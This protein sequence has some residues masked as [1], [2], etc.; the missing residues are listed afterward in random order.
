MTAQHGNL[1]AGTRIPHAGHVILITQSD[2]VA[3]VTE[4]CR[5][6]GR[7]VW[8]YERDNVAVARI[9]DSGRA[10]AASRQR[11]RAV[12]SER[13]GI[14]EAG[15]TAERRE[16]AGLPVPER[17]GAAAAAD[18]DGFAV[19]AEYRLF[20][21]VALAGTPVDGRQV[22]GI[23]PAPDPG[24]AI[25]A[26]GDH[27]PSVTAELDG[28]HLVVGALSEEVDEIASTA[29]VLRPDTVQGSG[30]EPSS[31]VAKRHLV[32]LVDGVRLVG[33]PLLAGAGVKDLQQT[34]KLTFLE[35]M[36]QVSADGDQSP[37]RTEGRRELI[38]VASV[39]ANGLP[40]AP[41]PE[42]C[43][44]VVSGGGNERALGIHGGAPQSALV[45]PQD[46]TDM[47]PGQDLP[48]RT[49]RRRGVGMEKLQRLD[50]AGRLA[51][52][53]LWV[54]PQIDQSLLR[55]LIHAVDLSLPRDGCGGDR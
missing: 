45:L 7:P 6:D 37:V 11:T 31:V 14:D 46:G 12:R 42:K 4:G 35:A 53:R 13:N 30:R 49:G 18:G 1:L 55:L 10:V 16:G 20:H 17:D 8:P 44:A 32:D 23:G 9:P 54:V 3:V 29:H 28:V 52:A 47:R 22:P 33:H 50:G 38:E 21:R 15:L 2:V 43:L 41:V 39:Q 34:V 19:R 5:P 40:R 27:I 51:H 36:R 26:G 48:E 24:R 25:R